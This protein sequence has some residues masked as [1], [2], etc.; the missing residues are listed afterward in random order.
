MMPAMKTLPA[1]FLTLSALLVWR[2]VARAQGVD[3]RPEERPQISQGTLSN[4]EAAPD[5]TLKDVRGE[6]AVTLSGLRGRPVVLIFGSCTCPPFVGTS[7]GAAELYA[8]YQDR[9]HFYLVYLREAHPTDGW[10]IPNNQ[11]QVA[12]PKSLEERQKIARA[13]VEKLGVT[14]PV[15]VDGIDDTVGKTYAGWPNRMY[16]I[17]AKGNI[18]YKGTASPGGVSNSLRRARSVL[19][20]LLEGAR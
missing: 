14:M 7:R 19:D 20:G 3:R 1:L 4:G 6:K 10:A 2:P 16:I 12:T 11:F 5:F 8:A 15:L 17:D 13:F 9:V 18:A